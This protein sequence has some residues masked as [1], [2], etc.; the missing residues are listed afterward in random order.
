M[1][2]YLMTSLLAFCRALCMWMLNMFLLND[3]HESSCNTYILRLMIIWFYWKQVHW[4]FSDTINIFYSYS[5][6]Y[7]TYQWKYLNF[8]WYNLLM[9]KLLLSRYSIILNNALISKAIKSIININI[10][11]IMHCDWNG[12]HN[13]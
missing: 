6:K 5:L 13:I 10:P 2:F 11:P 7:I 8:T 12:F 9:E 4:N 1:S 3:V